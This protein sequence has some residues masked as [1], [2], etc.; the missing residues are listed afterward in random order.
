MA[1][2]WIGLTGG[3]ATGKSSVAEILKQHGIPVVDADEVARVVVEKGTRGL[4]QVAMEFGE[5]VLN[6]N[7]TLN[8]KNLGK[9]V[10]EDPKKL[11]ILEGI[12]HPLIR[13]QVDQQKEDLEKRGHDLAVYDVPLLFEKN[14][15]A[16][17]ESIIVVHCKP[18]QQIERLMKRERLTEADA[19]NRI[20][21]QLKLEDKIKKAKFVIDNSGAPGA[22]ERQVTAVIAKLG[23]IK[24]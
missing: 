8:R 18:V 15:E 1:L 24:S 12:L 10:F 22:L 11:A 2:R 16:M 13:A 17:F 21:Q 7:G 9:I 3:I 20:V 4:E 14:M 5:K 6:D 19:K 23:A